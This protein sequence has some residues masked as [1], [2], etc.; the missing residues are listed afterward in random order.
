MVIKTLVEMCIQ[1]DKGDPGIGIKGSAGAPGRPGAPG[2][3]GRL[4]NSPANVTQ[5]KG[6]KVV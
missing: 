2:I 6:D 3:P 5:I 4:I 1:G